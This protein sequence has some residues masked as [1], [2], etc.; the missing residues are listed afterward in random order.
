[1]AREREYNNATFTMHSTV[2]S[3]S[4]MAV[5]IG[6]G[7]QGFDPDMMSGYRRPVQDL[8]ERLQ[9]MEQEMQELRDR[10]KH[11]MGFKE[12]NTMSRKPGSDKDQYALIYAT[13]CPD[14]GET[15]VPMS[16]EEAA[17]LS[18]EE[19]DAC[20]SERPHKCGCRGRVWIPEPRAMVTAVG[21]KRKG[22]VA[23]K[24][25]PTCDSVNL[26]ELEREMRKAGKSESQIIKALKKLLSD[27]EPESD[28]GE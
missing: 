25:V 27:S 28:D 21:G 20:G 11:F 1:M 16:D 6:G 12:V 10:E 7:Y 4:S 19:R 9:A 26:D 8:D 24:A 3:L 15:L 17:S 18:K 23:E 22:G 13:E 2:C 14:C 5:G